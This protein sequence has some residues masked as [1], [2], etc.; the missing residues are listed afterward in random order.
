MTNRLG[1]GVLVAIFSCELAICRPADAQT[2]I[3]SPL[4]V[5]FT[6]DATGKWLVDATGTYVCPPTERLIKSDA[7][8]ERSREIAYFVSDASFS[9][10]ARVPHSALSERIPIKPVQSVK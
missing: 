8:L 2:A 10:V 7:R 3:P 4:L 1:S 5:P 9:A 6:T